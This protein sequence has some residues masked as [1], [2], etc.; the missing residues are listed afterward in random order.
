MLQSSKTTQYKENNSG[1]T[2]FILLFIKISLYKCETA[3]KPKYS[4]S[5]LWDRYSLSR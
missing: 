1:T 4:N 5:M 2:L 3:L